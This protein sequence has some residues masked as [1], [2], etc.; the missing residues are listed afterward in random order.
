MREKAAIREVNVSH[1]QHRQT[2][3]LVQFAYIT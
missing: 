1:V 3:W 2:K